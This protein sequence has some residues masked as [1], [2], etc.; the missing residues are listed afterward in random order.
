M[1]FWHEQLD[2]YQIS[3]RY[4]TWAYQVAKSLKGSDQPAGD[5]LLR[6]S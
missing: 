1:Q 5:Q 6:A 4:V 2:V 3:I